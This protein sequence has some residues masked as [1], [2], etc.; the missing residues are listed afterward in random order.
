MGEVTFCK[1]DDGSVGLY[2]AKVGD[3]YHSTYGAYSEAYEKFICASNF[4]NFIKEHDS[5][6]I[7]DICYGI[8]YNTKTALNE[9]LKIDKKISVQIDALEYDKNLINISPFIK[10]QKIDNTINEFIMNNSNFDFGMSFWSVIR[11][12]IKARGISYVN[13]LNLID[14]KLVNKNKGVLSYPRKFLCPLVHNI[15]YNYIP[16]RYKKGQKLSKLSK[17]SLKFHSDDARKSILNLRGKYDFVFLDAFTPK[18]LPTLWSYEFFKELYRLLDDNGI[19]VT[20]SSSVA[21]RSAM[22]ESGF[23]VGRSTDNNGKIIGT[24]AAKQKHLIKQNLQ[25]VDKALLKSKAGIYYRD[26]NLNSSESSIT[27]AREKEVEEST[28]PS[29][30]SVKKQYESKK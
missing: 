24:V 5:V 14:F 22:I 17:T 4:S 19:I 21:V 25:E 20:Y 1:T 2:N 10:H 11:Y 27:A 26:E 28:L 9:I 7:L 30:S 23:F 6:R 12:F 13:W 18:K 8:G 3:I 15:Y 16:F 29:S